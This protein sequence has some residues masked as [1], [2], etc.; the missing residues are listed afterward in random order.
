MAGRARSAV[1]AFARPD[2]DTLAVAGVLTFAT[3]AR[4]LATGRQALAEGR[5]TRLD[6]AG[7]TRADSAG[8]AC[9]IALAAHAR[10]A[11]SRL[12]VV[13]WPS[14]LRALAD[15]CDVSALLAAPPAAG[16]AA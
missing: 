2:T 1:V 15:V 9:V 5:P 4:A 10:A 3:A 7:V 13:N 14:G 8:L 12:A 16:R 11:G 6:L